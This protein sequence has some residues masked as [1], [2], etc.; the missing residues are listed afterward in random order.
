M[1]N[2]GTVAGHEVA[3]LLVVKFIWT[4]LKS[5]VSRSLS[6]IS[7]P[8]SLDHLPLFWKALIA[9]SWLLEALRQSPS[10]CLDM[11]FPTGMLSR[12][13][14]SWRKEP[15]V[16]LLVRVAEIDGWLDLLWSERRYMVFLD[17]CI[18]NLYLYN[19]WN[20]TAFIGAHLD[21]VKSNVNDA[22]PKI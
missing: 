7:L 17:D 8:R 3:Y 6:S 22:S 4:L 21:H 16:L 15:R 19:F 9:Y 1:K 20:L 18:L 13:V 5:S 2:N 11:I 10:R 12:R 14:G